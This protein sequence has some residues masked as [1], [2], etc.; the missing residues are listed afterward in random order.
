MPEPGYLSK[1]KIKCYRQCPFKYKGIYEDGLLISEK[2]KAF[3]RGIA[4]HA[5]LDKLGKG[6]L[7]DIPEEY[8]K[9]V[10]DVKEINRK[11][12]SK[13][14][15]TEEIIY[16]RERLISGIIDRVDELED[17]S[18]LL[19]DYK[20]GNEYQFETYR[21]EL[22][23]YSYLY[24][25]KYK[26]RIKYIAIFFVEKNKLVYEELK[27]EDIEDAL[28]EVDEVDEKIQLGEFK[29]KKG[30]WCSYCEMYTNGHCEGTG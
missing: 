8:K 9:I 25:L 7:I 1:S 13:I 4:I 27:E 21:F 26:R 12:K 18:L 29:M 28:D 3:V 20:S 19:L 14:I 10:N 30:F 22:A 23:L 2:P 11:L 15:L 6:T 16:D 5:A 24:E 17:G